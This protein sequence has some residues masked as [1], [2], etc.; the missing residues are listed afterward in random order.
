[1]RRLP[2]FANK[3]RELSRIAASR[4][5]RPGSRERVRALFTL[6]E[7]NLTVP[8]GLA[9]ALTSSK[10]PVSGR[11]MMGPVKEGIRLRA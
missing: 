9:S 10:W 6:V 1:M 7:D 4:Y 11:R 2:S 3:Q 8:R 5:P